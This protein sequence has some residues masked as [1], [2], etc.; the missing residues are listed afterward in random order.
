MIIP[1]SFSMEHCRPCH[2]P[3]SGHAFQH[4]GSCIIFPTSLLLITGFLIFLPQPQHTEA[5]CFPS[6]DPSFSGNGTTPL[7]TN[8]PGFDHHCAWSSTYFQLP[9]IPS[10]HLKLPSAGRDLA[11]CT[12]VVNCLPLATG[13]IL[14][15]L[16][17]TP[18]PL[19]RPL[20]FSASR[21]FPHRTHGCD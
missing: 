3:H 9:D 12:P 8:I 14:D 6:Q 17:A 11:D 5:V 2:S 15:I 10:P 21:G 13:T 19:V 4:L 7:L 1:S 20:G 18:L 16:T